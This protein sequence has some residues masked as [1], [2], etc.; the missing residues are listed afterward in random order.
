[1]SSSNFDEILNLA[2][3]GNPTQPDVEA[4]PPAPPPKRSPSKPLQQQAGKVKQQRTARPADPWGDLQPPEKEP[5][6]RLNVDI[7][8]SL[9]DKLTRKAQQ[10][11]KPKT[12]LVRKLL[13]WALDESNE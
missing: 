3:G 1:M 8:I 13:E 12:E 10:V 7:P 9:N 5:T 6:I 11:R 4:E 2:S